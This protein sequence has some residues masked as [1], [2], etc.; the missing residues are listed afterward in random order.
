[1]NMLLLIIGFLATAHGRPTTDQ[2][3][4]KVLHPR[5]PVQFSN[6]PSVCVQHS[7]AHETPSEYW[8]MK[9]SF[10]PVAHTD[11]HTRSNSSMVGMLD[12]KLQQIG[13]LFLRTISIGQMDRSDWT[14]R[15]AWMGHLHWVSRIIQ[16][17]QTLRCLL[18]SDYPEYDHRVV[19]MF[20]LVILAV[21]WYAYLNDYVDCSGVLQNN[22]YNVTAT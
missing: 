10:A 19:E 3:P 2:M 13:Y 8:L 17:A 20:V 4:S 7:T 21:E 12:S 22:C 15:R 1:M 16:F 9:L 18:T 14:T 6:Y 5:H 11:T